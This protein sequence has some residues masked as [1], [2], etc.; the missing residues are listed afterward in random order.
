[1]GAN[2]LFKNIVMYCSPLLL[3][4]LVGCGILDPK[5]EETTTLK[6]W[7]QINTGLTSKT[8]Q[9]LVFVPNSTTV[10]YAGTLTG[11]FKTT[12]G[13]ESWQPINQGLTSKDIKALIV[14]PNEHNIL[15]CGTWGDGVFRSD[16]SGKSWLPA[17]RVNIDPRVNKLA[18]ATNNPDQVWAATD[19]GVFYSKDGGDTWGTT[20][21]NNSV[22]SVAVKPD[23]AETVYIGIRYQGAMKTEDGGKHWQSITNGLFKSSDGFVSLNSILFHPANSAHIFV[24][25]GWVDIY[26]TQDGGG[27]WQ[28]IGYELNDKKVCALAIHPQ[29]FDVLWAATELD[30]VWQSD[31]GGET[32]VNFSEGL[33]TLKSKC[34]AV[35]QDGTLYV[36]TVGEGIFKYV[37]TD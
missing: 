14:H 34:L 16:D 31:D 1:M 9:A 21:T 36:G 30:G 28:Q 19:K 27:V 37:D 11:L 35:A 23:D 10:G 15:Y 8:I 24:S 12:N 17:S 2:R 7:Q 4:I 22:L 20:P 29:N 26:T 18:V 32:W 3:L 25:T 13:G 5:T 33:P 6:G